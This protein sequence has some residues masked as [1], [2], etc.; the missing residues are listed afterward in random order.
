MYW[1]PGMSEEEFVC[2][3]QHAIYYW[4]FIPEGRLTGDWQAESKLEWPRQ[5]K[6]DK[7]A[8][9]TFWQFLRNTII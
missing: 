3:V 9:T 5:P 7:A 1:V 8:F 4:A 2:M 6:P